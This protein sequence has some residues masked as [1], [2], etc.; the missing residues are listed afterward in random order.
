[1]DEFKTAGANSDSEFERRLHQLVFPQ[2]RAKSPKLMPNMVGFELLDVND[3]ESQAKGVFAFRLGPQQILVPLVFSNGHVKGLNL[4]HLKQDNLLLPLSEP[5]IDYVLSRQTLS[6][7]RRET[8]EESRRGGNSLFQ[9][10]ARTLTNIG[11]KI[12]SA[13]D[14]SAVLPMFAPTATSALLRTMQTDDDFGRAVLEFYPFQKLAAIADRVE[15]PAKPKPWDASKKPMAVTFEDRLS[16]MGL[17]NKQ[18]NDLLR[19]G[20]AFYDDRDIKDV[21]EVLQ[22]STPVTWYAPQQGGIYDLVTDGG[23]V[24]PAAVFKSLVTVGEGRANC[25]VVVNL[26][27]NEYISTFLQYLTV[28]GERDQWQKTFDDLPLAGSADLAAGDKFLLVDS[29]MRAT[30]PLTYIG[31]VSR[32]GSSTVYV[33]QEDWPATPGHDFRACRADG[34]GLPGPRGGDAVEMFVDQI[35]TPFPYDD[36]YSARSGD[37]PEPCYRRGY[38]ILL[39]SEES[40]RMQPA[41]QNLL[42]GSE[43]RV[44]KLDKKN[45]RL[46][47]PLTVD[48]WQRVKQ[49]DTG[50]RKLA[51]TADRGEYQ[52]EC[53]VLRSGRRTRGGALRHLVCVHGL[54]SDAGLE[55]LK[56]A[57]AAEASG[58]VAAFAV[59]HAAAFPDIDADSQS[60]PQTYDTPAELDVGSGD[61]FLARD[62]EKVVDAA[63]S[64]EKAVF[65]A[66]VINSLFRR[67]NVIGAIDEL[68]GNL[69]L[70]L[71]HICRILLLLYAHREEL[72]DQFGAETVPQLE[73]SLENLAE[74]LG[75]TLLTL[76]KKSIETQSGG[77]GDYQLLGLGG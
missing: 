48:M 54:S 58:R 4:M 9:D 68:L 75:D 24:V 44:L 11:E 12:A 62:V 69:T 43:V 26:E 35:E 2:I 66:A 36:K 14:L 13:L 39:L 3:D 25:G 6:V 18:R 51:A 65:D 20:V 70:G 16:S 7:G 50:L 38:S 59:K 77:A 1:M 17:D 33:S 28:T 64:G 56:A 76:K 52:V 63:Q 57:D 27:K 21:T 5:L 15:A 55:V 34:F 60:S 41:G 29:K 49:A 71:D 10:V 72:E 61:P 22:L 74:E 46:M 67:H 47:C 40:E 53:G 73:D 8:R 19:N 30:L 45:E 31:K 23:E 32:T 37:G 42:V